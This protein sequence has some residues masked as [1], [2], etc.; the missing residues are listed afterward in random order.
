MAMTSTRHAWLRHHWQLFT[1]ATQQPDVNQQLRQEHCRNV[2]PSWECEWVLCVTRQKS[3]DKSLSVFLSRPHSQINNSSPL[4]CPIITHDDHCDK[5]QIDSQSAVSV[6]KLQ[7][8][9]SKCEL[10]SFCHD[11]PHSQPEN[12][13]A[14]QVRS[15]NHTRRVKMEKTQQTSCENTRTTWK[16]FKTKNETHRESKLQLQ[17]HE[18]PK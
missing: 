12:T 7:W 6:W 3:Q 16:S 9:N 2:H 15:R 5:S 18:Q 4:Y 13:R 11:D 17:N 14:L 1:K 8:K 10:L